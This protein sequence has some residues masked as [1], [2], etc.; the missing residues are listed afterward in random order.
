[1]LK[2]RR[3]A[4]TEHL[5]EILAPVE[6]ATCLLSGQKYI[7]ASAVLPLI[8]GLV[9]KLRKDVDTMQQ[10]QANLA[11]EQE[12]PKFSLKSV[13]KKSLLVICSAV[14]PRFCFLS[15]AAGMP[16]LHTAAIKA[17]IA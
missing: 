4:K 17:E 5:V 15:F 8:T 2:D 13:T 7:T 14:D 3:W 1:M 16:S 6:A 9:Q 12:K 10:F 11:D